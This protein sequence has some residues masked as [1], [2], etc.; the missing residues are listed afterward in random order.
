MIGK[1]GLWTVLVIIA[2]GL[3][4]QTS[5]KV[6]AGEEELASLQRQISQERERIRVLTAEW[7]SL[8]APSRL[9]TLADRHTD[10]GTTKPIQIVS[11]DDVPEKIAPAPVAEVQPATPAVAEK[12]VT[13]AEAAP[14]PAPVKVAVAAP[15]KVAAAAPAKVAAPAKKAVAKPAP[16]VAMAEPQREEDLIRMLIEQRPD[17]VGGMIRASLGVQ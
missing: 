11:L 9:Q 12:V 6:K 17:E 4:L 16:Q 2:A 15:V 7:A 14:K 3:V 5:L 10:L 13:V 1:A 8:T